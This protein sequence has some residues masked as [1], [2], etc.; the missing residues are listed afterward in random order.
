MKNRTVYKN[1]TDD[2]QSERAFNLQQ[3]AA[4]KPTIT[5]VHTVSVPTTVD[6]DLEVIVAPETKSVPLPKKPGSLLSF[7]FSPLRHNKVFMA[8]AE[9]EMRIEIQSSSVVTLNVEERST[10]KTPGSDPM[11]VVEEEDVALESEME[12]PS[13]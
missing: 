13:Y 5:N 1:Y 2:T 11:D 3:K 4:N 7:L 6:P 10:T 8:P 9:E 12:R